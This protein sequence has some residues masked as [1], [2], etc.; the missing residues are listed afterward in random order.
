MDLF[1]DQELHN[2]W[3][4]LYVLNG[5]ILLALW[6]WLHFIVESISHLLVVQLNPGLFGGSVLNSQFN[7]FKE[8]WELQEIG[9]SLLALHLVLKDDVSNHALP[10]LVI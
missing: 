4:L 1:G 3:S 8:V 10:N 6:D 7:P 2:L 5:K 9:E